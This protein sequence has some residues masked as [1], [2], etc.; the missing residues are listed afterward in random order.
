MKAKTLTLLAV[1]LSLA[2]PSRAFVIET[3]EGRKARE[4]KI[5]QITSLFDFKLVSATVR[6]LITEKPEIEGIPLKQS[7]LADHWSPQ[8]EEFTSGD[9]WLSYGGGKECVLKLYFRGATKALDPGGDT[10]I[11]FTYEI[12]TEIVGQEKDAI[13]RVRALRYLKYKITDHVIWLDGENEPNQPSLPI[14]PSRTPRAGARGA[15]ADLLAG[16]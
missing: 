16:L 11:E 4:E 5:A 2:I 9:W 3:E 14:R 12:E 6:A 10:A 13:K 1:L 7:K 8:R 15:P